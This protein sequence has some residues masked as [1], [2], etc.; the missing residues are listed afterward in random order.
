VPCLRSAG[1]GLAGGALFAQPV[2]AGPVPVPVP[3]QGQGRVPV[4][5]LGSLLAARPKPQAPSPLT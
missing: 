2:P 1:A 3:G 5:G 4:R